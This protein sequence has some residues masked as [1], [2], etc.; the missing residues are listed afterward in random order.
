[1]GKLGIGRGFGALN[2]ACQRR[3]GWLDFPHPA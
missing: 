2:R 3:F 1:M